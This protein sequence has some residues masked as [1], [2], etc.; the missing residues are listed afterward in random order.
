MLM[1]EQIRPFLM[2]E[3]LAVREHALDCVLAPVNK[4]PVTC[5]DLWAAVDGFG[6]E[7][8]ISFAAA[9]ARCPMTRASAVRALETVR[10]G[11]PRLLRKHCADALEVMELEVLGELRDQVLG[12]EALDAEIRANL[13]ERLR[14]SEAREEPAVLFERLMTMAREADL[15]RGPDDA[16]ASRLVEA[17]GR[18]PGDVLPRALEMLRDPQVEDWRE[19][20]CI[21]LVGE[22]RYEPAVETLIGKLTID[23]DVMREQVV[24]A[25][26]RIATEDVVRRLR[27]FIPGKEWDVRL[28]AYEP[29][30]G[31][32]LPSA[33]DALAEAMISDPDRSLRTNAAQSLC[34]QCATP[35]RLE[36]VRK[37]LRDGRF[38][39]GAEGQGVRNMLA[40]AS[41]MAGYD[42]PES[43][44][45]LPEA[46][47]EAARSIE[48]ARGVWEE[49]DAER[50]LDRTVAAM[51][52]ALDEDV[53]LPPVAEDEDDPYLPTG[54]IHRE[55]PKVGRN[56]PCRCGSG[57]KYKKCCGKGARARTTRRARTRVVGCSAGFS[58]RRT[59][60][61]RLKPAPQSQSV[62]RGPPRVTL[63]QHSRR[64]AQVGGGLLHFLFHGLGGLGL[65]GANCG[66]DQVLKHL[67]VGG[68]HA[69][70]V[71]ADRDHL[72]AP[73][74]GGGD[75]A[76]AGVGRDLAAGQL[77]LHALHLGLQVLGAAHQVAEVAEIPKGV[78]HAGRFM[79]KGRAV[80]A[81]D[82]H[83]AWATSRPRQ[84]GG[85][86]EG[87]PRTSDLVVSVVFSRGDECGLSACNCLRGKDLWRF[88]FGI[89]LTA[90]AS[91]TE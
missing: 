31:I 85:R 43:W 77:V 15:E 10:A 1:V 75:H 13:S 20:L 84:R 87:T 59:G 74:H 67:G 76:A 47:R 63:R 21:A 25:L 54:P 44:K 62:E 50:R 90:D 68:V 17:L 81:A 23:A 69:G 80:K 53:G 37:A 51:S 72:A 33:E 41:V 39:G 64:D 46:Q 61:C 16:Q 3:N 48:L 65:G 60:S 29:L 2:H 14:L 83:A 9:L 18:R 8:G 70:F 7:Q 40:A 30:E 66:H 12:C 35:Q 11:E 78:E 4:A 27:Q 91:S 79:H 45:W 57:K 22:A 49:G 34:I 42:L 73:I 71:N 38:D 58:L 6:V 19:V 82:W 89:R 24:I 5:D 26:K 88:L 55:G 36:M 28:Y 56:D 32:K 86:Y 52:A